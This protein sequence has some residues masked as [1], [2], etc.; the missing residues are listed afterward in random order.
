MASTLIPST[1]LY[2]EQI[3]L[4]VQRLLKHASTS[5]KKGQ[6]KWAESCAKDARDI[7]KHTNAYAAL[8]VSHICLADVYREVGELGKAMDL[9]E[10]AYRIFH[11]QS[12]RAQRHNE[13]IA[14]YAQGLLYEVLPFGDDM[15]AVQWY[16]KALKLFEKAQEHWASCRNDK[17]FKACQRAS[18]HIERRKTAIMKT[19]SAGGPGSE[20]LDILEVDSRQCA[21]HGRILGDNRVS[22]GEDVFCLHS[23]TLPSR[24][25]DAARYCF[26]LPV[27]NGSCTFPAA[28]EGDY[29]VVRLRWHLNVQDPETVWM[30]G[31]V[32]TSDNAWEVGDFTFDPDGRVWFYPCASKARVIGG[33]PLPIQGG[34]PKDP[35]EDIKG[36]IIGLLKPEE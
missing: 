28:E 22:V 29:A 36:R 13:A 12:P 15:Q 18:R 19:H 3:P 20:A 11:S 1:L 34:A 30:P 21:G 14:A 27:G 24:Y 7:C 6:W 10:E 26:L 33:R 35:T 9:C 32:W 2:Y 16:S 8:G 4:E 31:V 23:G 5:L 25:D 17:R